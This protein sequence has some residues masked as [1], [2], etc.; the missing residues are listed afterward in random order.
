MSIV[1]ISIFLRSPNVVQG[2]K[3][4]TSRNIWDD[5]KEKIFALQT[6]TIHKNMGSFL[7]YFYLPVDKDTE[8]CKKDISLLLDA[9]ISDPEVRKNIVVSVTTPDIADLEK[10]KTSENAKNEFFWA[11]ASQQ[12]KAKAKSEPVEPEPAKSVACAPAPTPPKAPPA[13]AENAEDK[14]LTLAEQTEKFKNFKDAL[15]EKVKGQR[16]AVDTVVRGIFESE[17]FASQNEER[18]G[19]LATFLFTG[20]S[21]VGKTHLADLCGKL[22]NRPAHVIDMS[23]YSDNLANMKFNG[24]HGAPAIVTGFVRKHPNAILVFDEI[25]KAHINTIHLF[26]QILDAGRLMDLKIN[27]EVSFKD[28][29]IIMTTNAGKQLYEDSTVCDLSSTPRSVILDALKNDKDPTTRESFFPDCIITRMANGNVILFNHLEPF[30][31]M[32]IVE[33]EIALQVGLFEKSTGVKVEYDQKALASLVLFNGGGIADA[34]TLRGLAKNIV[35]KELQD[36]LMQVANHGPN[37]VNSLKTIT[38]NVDVEDSSD[39]ARMLFVSDE[40]MHIAVFT[41]KN[42]V[43]ASGRIDKNVLFVTD[44]TDGFKKHLR[45]VVDYIILDPLCQC[46]HSERTPNDIED[47]NSKGMEMFAYIRESYP[48]IP[49]F[50]LD[51]SKKDAGAFDSL[52]AN[53]ARGVIDIDLNSVDSSSDF[54]AALDSLA[55]NSRINNGTFSLGRT[56]KYLT[57]NCAQYIIDD[58]HA[59]ISFERL[60]VKGAPSAADSAS[61]I[62]KG[63]NSSIT[64]ADVVGCKAAKEALA[65]YCKALDDARSVALSGKKMPKGILLYGPPGTGKTLLAKAMANECNATFFQASATSFFSPYVG[66][67]E[68]N[69]RELF[70]KARKYAPSIIFIDE[71]DA[72]GRQRTGAIGGQHNEDALTTFLAEMDGFVV[73]EKRPVFIFAATNYEIEGDSPRTLDAAFVRRFDSKIYIPLPD[74]DDR[75]ALLM[76]SLKKHGIHFGE[77]HEI[78]VRN[79]AE[80]T[81]G[82]NNADLEALNLQYARSLKDSAPTSAGY[83]DALDAYRFGEVNE[84]EPE[85]LRQTACHEAGHAIVCRLCGD[86][87]T[88]LT[89]VSRG[90]YGG[91]M[92]SSSKEGTITYDELMNIVCRCL[93]GRAAEIEL[94][95]ESLG[96]NTGASSDIK[97]A[98]Y[99]IRAS[100][101]DYA[102]GERLFGEWEKEDAEN[103]IRQQYE[104]TKKMLSEN[105]DALIHLTDL[106]AKEKSLDQSQM[107]EF[108]KSENL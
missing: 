29:I 65:D 35:V 34:R 64:F 41:D 46:S 58:T 67:T 81:G 73:D 63:Q 85:K 39:S 3:E 97:K 61:I 45:G 32:E 57:Y 31:L 80:R 55:Q 48:E 100:L 104:R 68:I 94:Y 75:Y 66:Q 10:L 83:L 33:K 62:K 90:N 54:S 40:D 77:N 108:F 23:E 28:T 7:H 53:G 21:G 8:Q 105:R 12:E 86:T 50:I 107:E 24:D 47:L 15:L 4:T 30:A 60:V 78:T 42:D 99:F 14:P 17:I 38:I 103:L 6:N 87:P 19:P 44:D 16:H 76:M 26:L 91:Y 101:D 2:Y 84:M 56:G 5:I 71:V 27:K 51:K 88:F 37:A 96:T 74:T 98:R 20:P 1:K 18:K 70:K 92:A 69:I 102:M 11:A 59:A 25:E 106:L 79:M 82:M 95:G 52:L 36:V 13:D 43:I 49:I 89:V 9:L 93:A 22:L 72:I